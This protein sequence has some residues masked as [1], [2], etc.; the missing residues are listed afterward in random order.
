MD[1]VAANTLE[2]SVTENAAIADELDRS[3]IVLENGQGLRRR[4]RASCLLRHWSENHVKYTSAATFLGIIFTFWQ[5]G[6]SVKQFERQMLEQREAASSQLVSDFFRQVGDMTA[7]ASTQH[8]GSADNHKEINRFIVSRAQMLI[9]AEQTAPFRNEIVRFLGSNGY[10]P[11]FGSKPNAEEPGINLNSADLDDIRIYGADFSG[12][13]FFCVGFDRANIDAT[14]FVGSDINNS[15]FTASLIGGVDFTSSNMRKV[16][17]SNVILI[18]QPI[19]KDASI[20]YSNLT[21]MTVSDTFVRGL[22]E[23][24]GDLSSEGM[25]KARYLYLAGLLTEAKSLVGTRMDT[26]LHAALAELLSPERYEI[27][28]GTTQ[29]GRAGEVDAGATRD[30]IPD[31]T[32]R[33]IDYRANCRHSLTSSA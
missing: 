33:A 14:K 32:I 29:P 31:A 20:L 21:G 6:L 16:D 11:F 4:G 28:T 10:G 23:E 24:R 26:E 30:S 22:A 12:A 19:F 2:K 25:K 18:G 27:M 13:N 7:L 8:T 17:F 1:K 15:E 5:L 9:D 3:G